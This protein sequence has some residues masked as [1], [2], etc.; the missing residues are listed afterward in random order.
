MSISEIEYQELGEAI[1]TGA[2]S[3]VP[4]FNM[5]KHVNVALEVK[6]GEATLTVAELFALKAGSVLT[7]DRAVDEPVDILLN[8]KTVASG[9][10]AVSG[11]NLGVRI[12]AI[13][14]DDMQLAP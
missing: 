7:L 11:D 6:V 1:A 9:H 3:L 12:T 8:G 5:L 10:L 14:N 13:H 2:A 4:N